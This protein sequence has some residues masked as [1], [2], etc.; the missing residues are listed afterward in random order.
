MRTNLSR[1][2]ELQSIPTPPATTTHRPI[3]HHEIVQALVET[4]GFRHIGVVRDEYAVSTDGM[5]MFGAL[6]LEYGIAGVNFSIGIRNANDKTMRLAIHFLLPENLVGSLGQVPG[7]RDHRFLMVLGAFDPPIELH[8]MASR[9]PTLMDH[10]QVAGLYERPLQVSVDVA[11]D[12]LH[13]GVAP[14][15]INT[16]YQPGVTGQV[17]GARRLF[18]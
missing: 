6:D 17:G 12:L 5:K 10:H 11:A 2:A 18:P 4:L 15:G 3:P 1:R 14:T 7:D 13:P 9:Q 8:H 16:W